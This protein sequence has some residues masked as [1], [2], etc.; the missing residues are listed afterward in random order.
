MP[1][2]K[3]RGQEELSPVRGQGWWTR[4]ATPHPRRGGCAGVG[5]PKGATPCSRSGGVTSSKVR[6]SSCA[7]L[8]QQ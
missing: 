7:L 5:G 2:F 1:E 4:G 8:E 3:G 6:S